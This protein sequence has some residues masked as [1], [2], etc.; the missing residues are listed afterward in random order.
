MKHSL[1]SIIIPTYNRVHLIGETLDS[2]LAQTYSNW[3]CIVI[4]D[5]STDAT[6]QLLEKYSKKDER[7]SYIIKPNGLKKGASTSR[8]LGL[9]IAKGEFIQFL[10]SD[11]IL[12]PNKIAAQLYL[13][14]KEDEFVIST[15]KW[16]KFTDLKEGL[17]VNENNADYKNFNSTKEYF[18]LIGLYGGFYP[19]LAFLVN[20]KLIDYS[21]HWNE[22]LSINDD[23]EFFFR[24]LSNARKILFSDNTYVLYR[25]TS[26]DNLSLLNSE[27]KAISLLNS[28]KIIEVLY[29]AKYNEQNSVYINKKKGSVYNELKRQYPRLVKQNRDFFKVQ[30]KNDTLFLK[31]TKLKKRIR[32]RLKIIFRF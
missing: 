21:G 31:F 23:G 5:F 10:D 28:W 12:A 16:G 1:V 20:R 2:I 32:N 18:N 11:D 15:C 8:N 24:I 7:I 25:N 3:E 17:K 13:L 30:I 22:S 9:K 29:V 4:D 27:N 14:E 26:L 6:Q 19:S